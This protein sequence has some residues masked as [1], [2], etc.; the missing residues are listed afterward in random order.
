MAAQAELLESYSPPDNIEELFFS[1]RPFM[2][3]RL[4]DNGRIPWQKKEIVDQRY[5]LF[6][7]EVDHLS[8]LYKACHY[9]DV[10]QKTLVMKAA[11]LSVI[12][13]QNS[14]RDSTHPYFDHVATGCLEM[15]ADYQPDEITVASS[16][17]H[18]TSEENGDFW[19]TYI[20]KA[21]PKEV[22]ETVTDMSKLKGKKQRKE[23]VDEKARLMIIGALL[24]NPRVS[25][26][27]IKGDRMHNMRTVHYISDPGRRR[28]IIDE[29]QQMYVP[30]AGLL[31][32]K[33]DEKELDNLCLIKLGKEYEDFADMV[34]KAIKEFFT[35][36]VQP[37]TVF[38]NVFDIDQLVEVGA[39][40]LHPRLPS[41][42]DIYRRIGNIK[43]V[44]LPSDYYLNIDA[45]LTSFSDDTPN[46]DWSREAL[47]LLNIL[48]VSGFKIDESFNLRAIQDELA[49][50]LTDSLP[51]DL[52][53]ES[54]GLNIHLTIFPQIAYK[55]EQISIASM[56]Y[57]RP[58]KDVEEE[59]R[60]ALEGDDVALKHLAG[61]MK[62]NYLKRKYENEKDLLDASYSFVRSLEPR[63]P[64]GMMRVVGVD[65]EDRRQF[66]QIS[67]GATVIDYAKDIF[68]STWSRIIAA[69]VKREGRM[70][71]VPFDYILSPGETVHIVRDLKGKSHWDPLWIHA[72][73]T[74]LEGRAKVQEKIGAIIKKEE[75]QGR[76]E[77][78][79]RVTLVGRRVIGQY[80]EP[81][82]RPLRI[83]VGHVK[84]VIEDC[85]PQV[86]ISDFEF[87]VGMGEVG[88][89]VI[90]MVAEALGPINRKVGIFRVNFKKD[91]AGQT[92][93]VIEVVSR[94]GISMFGSESGRVSEEGASWVEIYIDPND[95]EKAQELIK[96]LLSNK[97]CIVL[98]ME[99]LGFTTQGR[100]EIYP[101]RV[102]SRRKK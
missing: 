66:R 77:M 68:H 40:E 41:A 36:R 75:K 20:E 52:V 31:G 73:R 25:F 37:D 92:G 46:S 28:A 2:S 93:T 27:K 44:L 74:D 65:D 62:A 9:M 54:D 18:D 23:I 86:P 33:E 67:Q 48:M 57:H 91:H 55:R 94:M 76:S 4:D 82:N 1:V 79:N 16:I 53:R 72:F 5:G 97:K 59:G 26:I 35:S 83:D 14:Y 87:K 71:P 90:K 12:A 49:Y 42:H 84:E 10:A 100:T 101:V 70:V 47:G 32:L 99:T 102:N 60:L 69:E 80:L 15:V 95:M 78:R 43:N 29:T 58:P 13:L 98:G 19:Q 81:E 17:L 50:G 61:I 51:V 11:V 39:L 3:N 34:A 56:Y 64:M 45:V 85:C 30:L 89:D 88:E 63:L 7:I 6:P 8:N 22:V 38:K 21:M 96:A 24:D